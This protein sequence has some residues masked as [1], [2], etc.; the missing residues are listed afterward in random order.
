MVVGQRYR[1]TLKVENG[2]AQILTDERL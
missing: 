2:V 1:T